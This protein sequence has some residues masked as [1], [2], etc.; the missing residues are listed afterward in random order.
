MDGSVPLHTS[1]RGGYHRPSAIRQ[2]G[3]AGMTYNELERAMRQR[4][5]TGTAYKVYAL[6]R[7][8]EEFA[9]EP[10]SWESQVPD[11]A[12]EVAKV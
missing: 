11:W 9:E 7:A 6:M 1:Q 2:E 10:V 12:R 4:G 8:A 5:D 3:G